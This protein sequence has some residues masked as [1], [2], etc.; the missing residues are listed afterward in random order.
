VKN[1]RYV[2]LVLLAIF[3][4]AVVLLLLVLAIP[5]EKIAR[6]IAR[7]SDLYTEGRYSHYTP[8]GSSTDWI[9]LPVTSIECTM[10]AFGLG[11]EQRGLV[12]LFDTLVRAPTTLECAN[13]K[14]QVAAGTLEPFYYSRYWHGYAVLYRPILSTFAY[15]TLRLVVAFALLVLSVA[16][17]VAFMRKAGAGAALG[18][19]APLLFLDG[20]WISQLAFAPIWLIAA[21]AVLGITAAFR[22]TAGPL[23]YINGFLLIGSLTS[24]TDQLT[25]P[26][27][28]FLIPATALMW[29]RSL[30]QSNANY[31]ADFGLLLQLGL[32]WSVGY[33]GLWSLKFG[34]VLIH[35][36][37]AGMDAIIHSA[38]NRT[39]A[40][41]GDTMLG[42]GT[43]IATNLARV[44]A[45]MAVLGAAVGAAILLHPD[46][47]ALLKHLRNCAAMLAMCLLPFLWWEVFS[48]H[49]Y[50]HSGFTSWNSY[51]ILLPLAVVVAGSWPTPRTPGCP[52]YQT[53]MAEEAIS[54]VG[55]SDPRTLPDSL[56]D[57]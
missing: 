48:N 37:P 21:V 29:L 15:S 51:L 7:S 55:G 18:I 31:K 34:L 43:A 6:N 50:I 1:W 33:F 44:Y 54:A 14:E 49:S 23:R 20:N 53:S 38:V 46:R 36:G 13:L 2:P 12:D 11:A 19:F 9:R 56:R 24:F 32:A 4:S 35:E 28:T 41:A 57:R 25:T 22:P 42:F 8:L 52:K 17:V 45:N 39:S 5:S 30:N 10:L 47:P 26:L 3:S 27:A 16:A 40:Q